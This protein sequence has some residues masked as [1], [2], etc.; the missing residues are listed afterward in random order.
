MASPKASA[1][2]AGEWLVLI[3]KI[4]AEPTRLRSGAWRRLKALG[5]VYLQNSV[6]AFPRTPTA[7]RALRK[8]RHDIIEMSGT[9]VLLNSSIL[10]GDDTVLGAF[11]AARSDEFE[12]IVDRCEDFLKGLKKEWDASHFTYAEL[13]ENEVDYNKLVNWFQSVGERDQF[14]AEGRAAA[15]DGLSRCE[16]A[17]EEYAARVYAEEPEG[18]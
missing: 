15:E 7:E 2:D 9:A 11:Q 1:P 13:E 5:A 12:E 17:L 18:H 3:Y 4:P 16:R 6:A 8:L 14:G 10:V